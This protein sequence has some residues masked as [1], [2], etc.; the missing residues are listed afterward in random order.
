MPTLRSNLESK[1]IQKTNIAKQ[2]LNVSSLIPLV[3]FIDWKGVF[4]LI[5]R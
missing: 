2:H 3:S 4:V 1:Q 5:L